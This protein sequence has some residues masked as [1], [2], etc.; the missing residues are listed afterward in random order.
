[1]EKRKRKKGP[2]AQ[3]GN[4]NAAKTDAAGRLLPGKKYAEKGFYALG[5]EWKK[6][7]TTP[8]EMAA[9]GRTNKI[10]QKALL[11]K[12]WEAFRIM[13]ELT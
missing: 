1:M 13:E 7:E 3:D 11:K 12:M 5:Q 4:R 10:S 8:A 2:G 9:F 6:D